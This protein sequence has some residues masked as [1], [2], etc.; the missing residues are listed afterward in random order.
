MVKRKLGGKLR[1][2]SVCPRFS[3]PGFRPRFSRNLNTGD[4]VATSEKMATATN[5]I[6]HDSEHP[7]ALLLP[8]IP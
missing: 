6:L 8:L 7:S 3:V 4:P 1:K 5:T 2:R